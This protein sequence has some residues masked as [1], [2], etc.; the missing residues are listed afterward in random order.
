ME[1][2][3]TKQCTKCNL[4]KDLDFFGKRKSGLYGRSSVCKI[5]RNIE[6]KKQYIHNK[7]KINIRRRK[8]FNSE[9]NR[10]N[11]FNYYHKNKE[12]ISEKQKLNYQIN[13]QSILQYNKNWRENNKEKFLQLAKNYRQKN[14][15]V[16]KV[17]KSIKRIYKRFSIK[18]LN[19]L[20]R[21][22][23]KEIYKN[24]PKGFHVDHI[25]PLVNKN[26]CGLHVPWNLQYLEASENM[27]KN[28]KFDGTYDNKSW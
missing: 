5:C 11:C 18:L 2:L 4:E 7:D 19:N 21:N 10:I 27:I 8:N 22:E 26:V 13:K 3:L 9:K 24:C 25:I 6:I 17:S 23:L 28:N 12:K 16:D 20:N 15:E 1:Q 14:P